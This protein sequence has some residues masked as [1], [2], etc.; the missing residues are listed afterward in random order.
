[1]RETDTPGR[2]A[3]AAVEIINTSGTRA[4]TTRKIAETAGVNAAAVNYHFG[5]RENLVRHALDLTLHHLFE[6][7][8]M[9]LARDSLPLSGK[10]YFL[11][12][13]MMEGISRFPGLTRSYITDPE[14]SDYTRSRFSA[15]LGEV[16]E[17]LTGEESARTAICQA[18]Y[19]VLAAGLLPEMFEG[20][21]GGDLSSEE[22]RRAFLLP[23]VNGIPGINLELTPVM[24]AE[25]EVL[26]ELAF[27]E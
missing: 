8:T 22:S 25:M 7:W 19:S 24:Q 9:I 11:L 27:R 16:I 20:I 14:V 6:D 4:V 12:Y 18:V 5:S 10:L 13:Y 21:S 2:I 1:M 15:R 26:R 23:L 17:S 3:L